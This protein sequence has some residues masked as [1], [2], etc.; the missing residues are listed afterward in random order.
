[1]IRHIVFWKLKDNAEGSNKAENAVVLKERLLA[2]KEKIDIICDMEVGIDF[3]HSE[4]SWDVALVCEF[5]TKSDLEIYQKH[6]EHIKIV[7]FV[8][9]I[10]TD[11]AVVDYEI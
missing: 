10:R 4:Q 3:L 1:M 8:R 7:D 5:A 9:K 6:P 2:M 11:R